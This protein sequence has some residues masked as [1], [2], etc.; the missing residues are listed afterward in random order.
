MR[1]RRKNSRTQVPGA[2]LLLQQ[3]VLGAPHPFPEATRSEHAESAENP[4]LSSSTL[5][6]FSFL[7]V[8]ARI[9]K[10][11]KSPRINS[12]ESISPTYVAWRTGKTIIFLLGSYP[13]RL[14]KNSS[15][16]H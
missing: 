16:I 15:T 6:E 11:L 10:L 1:S 5:G 9:F 7:L 13:N 3:Q 12:K 8:K 2:L 4:A 14:C